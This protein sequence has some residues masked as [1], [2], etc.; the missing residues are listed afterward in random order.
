M[1]RLIELLTLQRAWT[2][3]PESLNWEWPSLQPLDDL[4]LADVRLKHAQADRMYIDA[5]AVDPDYLFHAR[6]DG[7][8]NTQLNYSE[9]EMQEYM[10]RREGAIMER[11][12]E[13]E[14]DL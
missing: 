5:Q 4:E 10:Q 6:H 9:E 12:L 3:K 1:N 13:E 2:N 11:A 14:G 8:F 7:G